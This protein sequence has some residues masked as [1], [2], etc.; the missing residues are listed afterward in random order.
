M[1]YYGNSFWIFI[2][3][4]WVLLF[5]LW[6]LLLWREHWH[7]HHRYHDWDQNPISTPIDI[8]KERYAKGEISK[9]EFETIKADLNKQS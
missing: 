2:S 4:L 6:P 9:D 1:L 5:I 7:E 3:F 8:A